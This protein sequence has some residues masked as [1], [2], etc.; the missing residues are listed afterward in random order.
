M[1][2]TVFTAFA[3]IALFLSSMLLNAN[4]ELLF[5][6]SFD[7]G[8][9]ADVAKGEPKPGDTWGINFL[10]HSHMLKK[11]MRLWSWGARDRNTGKYLFQRPP[12]WGHTKGAVGRIK[13]AGKEN[14]NVHL[15]SLDVNWQKL[16]FDSPD[17]LSVT[18]AVHHGAC[19]IQD[20]KLK[21]SY[22]SANFRM[23]V[24]ERAAKASSE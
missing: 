10:R 21:F 23:I 20:G 8:F 4:D 24:I 1:R 19:L 2:K 15:F 18:D 14:I 5:Y 12:V 11:E 9:D 22:G 6:A 17:G 7:R 13:F 3:L 16:G